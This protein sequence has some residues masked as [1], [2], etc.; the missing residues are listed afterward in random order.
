MR[1]AGRFHLGIGPFWLRFPY[2]TPVLINKYDE[3]MMQ[4][5][6]M[7]SEIKIDL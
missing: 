2:V 6:P 1:E 4:K 7:L 5:R 3:I